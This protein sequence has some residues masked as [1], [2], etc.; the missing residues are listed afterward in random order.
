MKAQCM[1][2]RLK[3]ITTV[4]LQMNLM[5]PLQECHSKETVILHHLQRKITAADVVAEAR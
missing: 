3:A 2:T 1:M 5:T 4:G